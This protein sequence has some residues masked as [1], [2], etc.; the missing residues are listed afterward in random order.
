MVSSLKGA[1]DAFIQNLGQ[2]DARAQ[3]LSR[4]PGVDVW[5]T[6][7]GAVY[8][9]YRLKENRGNDELTRGKAKIGHVVRMEFVGGTPSNVL[10]QGEVEGRFNYFVGN[11]RSKWA[12][13]VPRFSEV[14]SERIYD[15][16]EARWY[17]DQGR[18]R[19]DLVV[20]PGADPARIAMRFEG[21][22]GISAKGTTLSLNTS[23]GE[24]QQRGLFAYQKVNGATKQVRSSF[25]V[26][27]NTVRFDL[28][29]YDR[30]KPLV[31]DPVVWATFLGGTGA[32][33]LSNMSKDASGNVIV[34]G[35][36]SSKDFPTSAGAYD[37]NANGA[38]SD[39]DMFVSKLSA[40]GTSLISSTYIGTNSIDVA[41]AVEVDS[42][43]NMIVVGHTFSATF[44][45][46][47]GFDSTHNGGYDGVIVKLNP[48]G[49]AIVWSTYLGDTGYDS[50]TELA[51]TASNDI[52][53]A[54]V[55]SSPAFP[56]GAGT[57]FDSTPNGGNDNFVVLVGG[58]G[59]LQ[60][61]T[62]YG[63]NVTEQP[64]GIFVDPSGNV[65]LGGYTSSTNLPMIA[66]GYDIVPNSMDAFV[67][68]FNATLSTLQASTHLGGA[69]LETVGGMDVDGSGNV[70]LVGYTYGSGFPTTV[71]AFATTYQG[72][73]RD[74][75]MAVF[76]NS[77]NTL[78]YSTFLGGSGDD[79]A[80]DVDVDAA[81][82]VVAS[83]ITWS[84][85]FK[86]TLG[87][88]D[89]TFGGGND[90]FLVYFEPGL[91]NAAE[92]TYIGSTGFES[93]NR[94]MLN[95]DRDV[96]L[97][98]SVYGADFPATAGAYD[99]THNGDEDMMIAR[100]K[101]GNGVAS[102]T[103]P[104]SSF[105]GGFAVPVTISL[106]VPASGP[107]LVSLSTDTPG[108]VLLPPNTKFR[109]G[110]GTKVFQARTESVKTTTPVTVTA[111]LNGQSK[112]ASFSLTVGGLLT[113]KISPPTMTSMTSGLGYVN[114]S[115]PAPETGRKVTLWSDRSDLFYLPQGVTISG[116]QT[117]AGFP[118]NAL[119]VFLS[120]NVTVYAS[121]GTQIKTDTVTLNP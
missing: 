27:G 67:A 107:T 120:D 101:V 7:Q 82:R 15:G 111:T 100:F 74:G 52:Y 37:E 10:G 33:T 6:D 105:I 97:V 94:I 86:T 116:G 68:K 59:T 40:D 106:N 57:P 115:G 80:R 119:L 92:S 65:I 83:G 28:G 96:T 114:L 85:D 5:L 64:S 50:A 91:G 98:L 77:L 93:V 26:E 34:C 32:D 45:V 4:S 39:D 22:Q 8:D 20:A 14:R 66:G 29:D 11:D 75:Y 62:L 78:N 19:Y 73:I 41:R 47:G 117:S 54:G 71:G 103:V 108:K 1:P 48:T 95:G 109:A 51:V 17:I 42:A 46:M 12:S 72:G 56:L 69:N 81:G 113:L 25:R 118:T 88:E 35:E 61:G 112:T 30:T 2:W 13:D 55:T 3:F 110:V 23:L 121:L 21:A 44:P 104:K 102:T 63:G 90:G 99:T 60:L 36:T 49:T 89:T 18:P 84:T 24:V 58:S 31:I 16:V 43:G 87:A 9:F 79:I 70:Y 38:G 53:V 76:N